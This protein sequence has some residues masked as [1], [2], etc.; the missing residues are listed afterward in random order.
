MRFLS[1]ISILLPILLT[2]C[3]SKH[4]VSIEYQPP[5]NHLDLAREKEEAL[6]FQE[7]ISEYTHITQN[8]PEAPYYK[9]AV[10][11]AALLHIHP[12]NPKTNYKAAQDWLQHYLKLSLSPG[13]K[14]TATVLAF[15]TSQIIQDQDGIQKLSSII[16]QQKNNLTVSTRKLNAAKKKA[17]KTKDILSKLKSYEEQLSILENKLQKMKDID[18]QMH[19]TRQYNTVD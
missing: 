3:F 6:N 13:E 8:H 16:E 5:K 18:I 17:A 11:R 10:F 19:K 4:P 15:L 12:E 7:A 9:T 1:I 14:E 2:G